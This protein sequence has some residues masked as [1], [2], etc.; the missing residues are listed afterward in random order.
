MGWNIA[1][2][3]AAPARVAVDAGR[4]LWRVPSTM[5]GFNFWGTRSDDA[6]MPEYRA[7]GVRLL[8]FPPGRTG[9]END[10]Q[11]S[12]IDDSAK[13]ARAMNG[14]LV[15]MVRLRGGTPERA[16]ENVRYTNIVKGY[17]ARFWEV[18]NEPDIYGRRPGEPEFSP[19]WYA[20]RF[21]AFVQAMKAVDPA[22]KIFGPVLSHKLDE[23][24]PPFIT[25]CGDIVD[26]LCWHFYG[27]GAKLPE[28]ELLASPARFD[29]QVTQVRRWWRDRAINPQGHARDIPLMI[30]EYGAS[31][32]SNNPRNLTTHAAALWTADMLGHLALN[33]IELAAYFTLWGIEYHGVWDRIGNV[34]PVHSTFLLFNQFGDRLVQA[35]SSQSLLAAYAAL[36]DDG[37]LTLWLVNKNPQERYHVTLD[38]T[39]FAPIAG[40]RMRLHSADA[41]LAEAPLD[42]ASGPVSIE[43]PP[44]TTAL[45]ELPGRE[46]PPIAP[47]ALLG[48]ALGLAAAAGALAV[49]RRRRRRASVKRAR[50]AACYS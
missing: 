28:P 47:V 40:G 49:I 34:R 20:E 46:A 2:R 31:Y 41:P 11:Q 14:D 44:Y 24:M 21:R 50:V 30:S 39:G 43:I 10:L 18:G 8:R 23:W 38:L 1:T 45:V 16:A 7:I 6:F 3:A 4:D 35:A 19:A 5:R 15:V 9:D 26:G 33:R 27:G 25:A 17:G 32:E 29:Q 36:R 37:V 48:G 42:T 22:I 13:V 12:L